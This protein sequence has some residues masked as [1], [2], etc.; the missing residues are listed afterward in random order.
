MQDVCLQY[1][2][3]HYVKVTIKLPQAQK[4]FTMNYGVYIATGLPS[5]DC[6]DMKLE[7]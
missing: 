2:Y 3:F 1:F 6:K 5:Y 4:R 7:A